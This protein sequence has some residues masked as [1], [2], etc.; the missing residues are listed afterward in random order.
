[1]R[2][3]D[4]LK[5]FDKV[6]EPLI[7]N[8]FLIRYRSKL[9]SQDLC[10]SVH[11]FYS[12]VEGD[13]KNSS[14]AE[15]GAGY[16]RL[17]YVF[18]TAFKNS[19]YCIVDISPALFVAQEYLSRMFPN[20]RI[21]YFRPFGTFSEIKEEFEA[22]RIRFIMAHQ[23]EKIPEKYFDIVIT[24]SSLHEMTREQIKNY[25]N[26]INRIGRDLVYTK[27]WRKSRTKDNFYIK[28]NEYPVPANWQVLYKR[29]HPIQRMFFEALYKIN[30]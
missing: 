18:L 8:P 4:K 30:I 11:E 27:Q 20:E 29:R 22:A 13:K 19:S 24:V 16:G 1:M 3:D 12:V 26:Q 17:A 10:N 28:E 25:F 5:I 6:E 14:V 21:F 2:R 7:G 15:I 23:I 9:I